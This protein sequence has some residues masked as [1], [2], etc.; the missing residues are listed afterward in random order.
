[1][2]EW[3]ARARAVI[4]GVLAALP[5]DAP[6]KQVRDAL[7]AAYPWGERANHPYRCWLEEQRLA[8]KRRGQAG[9]GGR[10]CVAF[11]CRMRGGDFP[12]LEVSCGWCESRF[13]TGGCMMCCRQR[14]QVASLVALPEYK[15]IRNASVKDE[16]ARLAL[17]D[18]LEERLG[19]RCG[20]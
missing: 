4:D 11:V 15:A 6:P 1:M 5:A 18:W 12:W 13:G 9:K 7:R 16:L 20:L 17:A 2:S 3:R 8:L 14:G 10:P 19:T